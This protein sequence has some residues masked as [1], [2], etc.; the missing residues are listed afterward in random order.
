[1]TTYNIIARIDVRR[2]LRF[3]PELTPQALERGLA[4]AAVKAWGGDPYNQVAFTVQLKR[5]THEAALSEIRE[6]IGQFAFYIVEATV[7]EVAGDAVEAAVIAA[8]GD[9]GFVPALAS[10]AAGITE[11]VAG[12]EAEKIRR[13]Y[14][15]RQGS[16][17][18]WLLTRR[19]Q[20]EPSSPGPQPGLSPA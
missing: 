2:A 8:L 12:A 15:A 6:F 20:Q 7:T 9:G 18:G 5:P 14:E 13:D 17:G 16:D 11:A 1:M 3:S 4:D 10:F 19:R